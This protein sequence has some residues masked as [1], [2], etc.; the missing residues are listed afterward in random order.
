MITKQANVLA[1]KGT[2]ETSDF[3]YFYLHHFWEINTLLFTILFV[4]LLIFFIISFLR[5][6]DVIID[7]LKGRKQ[8]KQP[9]FFHLFP[10]FV[11]MQQKVEELLDQQAVSEAL[12]MDQ[13]AR[14]NELLMYLA[15]DLKTPLT[16]LIGYIN[17]VL[18]HPVSLQEENKALHIAN[19]KAK[20]LNQLLD[21]FQEILR[22]DDKLSQ[23]F[24]TP[25]DLNRMLK[26]QF[27]GVY[28]LLEEKDLRLEEDLDEQLLIEGDYDKL[29]RVFD[30][31]MRNAI[32]YAASDSCIK[33]HS[34]KKEDGILLIYQ[35]KVVDIDEE[36]IK[37]LFDKFYR[38]QSART[39]TSGGAGLGLAIAAKIIELHQGHIE[40]KL[41]DDRI[42]FYVYLP[43]RAEAE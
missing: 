26:Q 16:S 1:N 12:A 23:L 5:S 4:S 40:A 27:V 39:S 34:E 7:T 21:E 38:A 43:Y 14:K 22:Y 28:P 19:T 3:Y 20:R 10:Q 25:I 33:V 36:A 31:L 9:L 24:M 37:H 15:H 2:L 17:H 35:N 13:R 32:T 42:Y 29:Q 30:N 6:L 11:M 18:D 41:K 8:A